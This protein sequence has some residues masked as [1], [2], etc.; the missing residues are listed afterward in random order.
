MPGDRSNPTKSRNATASIKLRCPR[1]GSGDKLR[2]VFDYPGPDL[3]E[4]SERGE[5][6]LGGCL[7]YLADPAWHCRS[8]VSEW[9]G[10]G[11]GEWRMREGRPPLDPRLA[12]IAAFLERGWDGGQVTLDCRACHATNS[13][14]ANAPG[15]RCWRCSK[16]YLFRV[17]PYCRTMTTLTFVAGAGSEC[18]CRSCGR[19]HLLN[20]RFPG[21]N[22]A[23]VLPYCGSWNLDAPGAHGLSP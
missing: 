19:G 8:R 22:H 16:S 4:K 21:T 23:A 9:S 15:Y 1:C 14:A 6:F 13:V 7:A 17:C 2:I 3:G 18:V 10:A 12:P 20:V 5:V 11:T